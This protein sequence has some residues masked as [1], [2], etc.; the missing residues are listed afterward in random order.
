V[1]NPHIPQNCVELELTFDAHRIVEWSAVHFQSR[2][3]CE[4][5][6]DTLPNQVQYM[7][8][9]NEGRDGS[10]GAYCSA[11]RNQYYQQRVEYVQVRTLNPKP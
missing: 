2:G 1:K 10:P 7:T 8:L 11:F 6:F 4:L 9:F 5:T 3:V